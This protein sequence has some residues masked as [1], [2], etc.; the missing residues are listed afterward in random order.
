LRFTPDHDPRIR[1]LVIT[2]VILAAGIGV[3]CVLTSDSAEAWSFGKSAKSADKSVPAQAKSQSETA[4]PAPAAPAA[5]AAPTDAWSQ[6]YSQAQEYAAASKY[7]QALAAAELALSTAEKE[8][9]PEDERAAKSIRAI[10]QIQAARGNVF[11][12]Q[13]FFDRA[14]EL[15]KKTKGL[16]DA[17]TANTMVQ[18]ASL[19]LGLQRV[20]EAEELFRTGYEVLR[21]LYGRDDPRITMAMGG[22][23]EVYKASGDTRAIELFQNIIR[24]LSAQKGPAD[25]GI[26]SSYY[27][28]ADIYEG[29]KDYDNAAECYFSIIRALEEEHGI[30]F[31]Q[32]SSIYNNLGLVYA[33]S[34][35]VEEAQ[36]AYRHS[37]D[38]L[39]REYGPQHPEVTTVLENLNS[40]YVQA[41]GNAS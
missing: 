6:A 35:H 1:S 40:V 3:A 25:A 9:G 41:A 8:Y 10:A 26:V 24:I 21:N 30:H 23:A 4:S 18:A 15:Y 11:Q 22:L 7:D 14:I 27:H 20:P 31:W 36:K 2:A 34:G 33:R 29:M 32:L 37:L 16:N 17:D 12:A 39:I 28:L 13:I 19:Y 38:I 5:P